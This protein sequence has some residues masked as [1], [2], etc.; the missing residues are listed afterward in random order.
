MGNGDSVKTGLNPAAFAELLDSIGGDRETGTSLANE[1]LTNTERILKEIELAAQKSDI[2]LVQKLAHQIKSS[3]GSMG[4]LKL[5]SLCAEL[6]RLQS[7]KQVSLKYL[8]I[9]TEFE[10]VRTD[11][12]HGYLA[13]NQQMPD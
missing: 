12:Q 10:Q 5:A 9:A 1:F 8:D 2:Q 3:C 4:A 13:N 11:L 7:A 6:E